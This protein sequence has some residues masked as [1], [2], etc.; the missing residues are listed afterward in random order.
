MMHPVQ[1]SVLLDVQQRQHLEKAS[2]VRAS[3]GESGPRSVSAEVSEAMPRQVHFITAAAAAVEHLR[4][5]AKD[6]SHL[7]M[8][9]PIGCAASISCHVQHMIH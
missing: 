9:S 5:S 2:R 4:Q 6:S 1:A 3:Q 7:E 8:G